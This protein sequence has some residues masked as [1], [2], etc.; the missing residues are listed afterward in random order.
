[1]YAGILCR[2]DMQAGLKLGADAGAIA[3]A[4]DT[5]GTKPLP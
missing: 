3:L 5:D 1:L 4:A 2:F